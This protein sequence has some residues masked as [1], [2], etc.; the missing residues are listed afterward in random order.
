MVAREFLDK[1]SAH[2]GLLSEFLKETSMVEENF[3]LTKEFFKES[4]REYSGR[5]QIPESHPFPSIPLSHLSPVEVKSR[6]VITIGSI[7]KFSD[8]I[9]TGND[10][11]SKSFFPGEH[12]MIPRDCIILFQDLLFGRKTF[13]FVESQTRMPD[14]TSYMTTKNELMPLP[15]EPKD[16][17]C[18]LFYRKFR[19]NF[20]YS[21]HMSM[22]DATVNEQFYLLQSTNVSLRLF[23]QW[24]HGPAHN[25]LYRTALL[26]YNH[27][28]F[29]SKAHATVQQSEN[30]ARKGL[31]MYIDP[32]CSFIPSAQF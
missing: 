31:C 25:K 26:F 8:V 6:A 30:E 23:T 28:F 32:L 7:H 9:Y 11:N 19:K 24:V 29:L 3:K 4:E 22:K 14:P 10:T 20:K 13:N 21:F 17:V 15:N 27:C 2:S 12:I 16:V 1:L 18:A 5:S